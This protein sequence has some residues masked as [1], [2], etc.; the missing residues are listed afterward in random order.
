MNKECENKLIELFK[1]QRTA[2][3]DVTGTQPQN[4]EVLRLTDVCDSIT[5][6]LLLSNKKYILNAEA[7]AFL[8]VR[9]TR[10]MYQGHLT[11]CDVPTLKN[12]ILT[13][14]VGIVNH[15]VLERFFKVEPA[16]PA[17]PVATADEVAE[18]RFDVDTD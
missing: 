9:A 11:Y 18:N 4:L 15:P 13:K 12:D 7:R 16:M 8:R 6:D 3:S 10:T 2:N 5:Y 17:M 14:L 1:K